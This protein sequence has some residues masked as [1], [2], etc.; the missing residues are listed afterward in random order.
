MEV[1]SHCRR[2]N[3]LRNPRAAL[4]RVRLSA[5]IDEDDVDFTAIVGI[6]RA[7]RIEHR[8]AEVQRKA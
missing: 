2:E 8:D 4:H 3:Q 7:R 5:K 1:R 6:E